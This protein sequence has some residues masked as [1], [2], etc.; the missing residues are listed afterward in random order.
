MENRVDGA[1]ERIDSV[2]HPEDQVRNPLP[3]F[4][5]VLVDDGQH[6]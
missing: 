2:S 4:H 1:G 5:D 6:D 3:A